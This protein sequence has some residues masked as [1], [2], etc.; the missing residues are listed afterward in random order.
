MSKSPGNNK[1][2]SVDLTPGAGLSPEKKVTLPE[3]REH[4]IQ[5][6]DE[7][8]CDQCGKPTRIYTTVRGIHSSC[9]PCKRDILIGHST[10]ISEQT[11]LPARGI[12]KKVLVPQIK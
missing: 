8:L 7:V 10:R 2:I 6:I 9:A 5:G 12:S 11:A 3:E 1:S 4:K